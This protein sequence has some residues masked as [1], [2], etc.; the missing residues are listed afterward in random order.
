[1]LRIIGAL[2]CVLLLCCACPKRDVKSFEGND[3]LMVEGAGVIAQ[4]INTYHVD[5]GEWPESIQAAQ[6]HFPPGTNWP[7]NPWTGGPIEDSGSSE[8]IPGKSEGTVYYEKFVRDDQ[9]MN[10]RM[11]IFGDKGRLTIL[12]NTAFGAE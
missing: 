6:S 10:Y 4:A 1:M 7:Q 8:F 9:I 12:G 11:H 3:R 2:L 5:T